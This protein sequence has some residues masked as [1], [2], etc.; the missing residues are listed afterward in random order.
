MVQALADV[1]PSTTEAGEKV[2]VA[3]VGSPDAENAT[4]LRR[5][6]SARL[7]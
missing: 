2:A 3:P 1:L 7:R 5:S 6:H 4:W